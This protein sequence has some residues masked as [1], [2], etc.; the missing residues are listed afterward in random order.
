MYPTIKEEYGLTRERYRG[1][2]RGANYITRK[3]GQ[4]KYGEE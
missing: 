4:F 3:Y 2:G 1:D